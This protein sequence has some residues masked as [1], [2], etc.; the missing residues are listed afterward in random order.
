MGSYE[1]KFWRKMTQD[2]FWLFLLLFLN[3]EKTTPKFSIRYYGE[4]SDPSSSEKKEKYS[5]KNLKGF[6]KSKLTLHVLE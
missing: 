4:D 5:K 3:D 2:W 1:I 6:G